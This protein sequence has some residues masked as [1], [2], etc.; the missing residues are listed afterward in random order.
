MAKTSKVVQIY[1]THFLQLVLCNY[2]LLYS[3]LLSRILTLINWLLDSRLVKVKYDG[4]SGPY[5]RSLS[6][7][8]ISNQG[9]FYSPPPWM[10]CYTARQPFMSHERYFNLSMSCSKHLQSNDLARALARP[11]WSQV[12]C[13]GSRGLSVARLSRAALIEEQSWFISV[14][15]IDFKRGKRGKKARVK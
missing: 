13:R 6:R 11:T 2:L 9:Y 7:F 10:G 8:P 14:Y 5:H 15:L 1:V 4:P 12:L 3:L